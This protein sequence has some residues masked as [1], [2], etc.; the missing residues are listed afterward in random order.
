MTEQ[1]Q[2]FRG[3]ADALHRSHRRGGDPGGADRAS[4]FDIRRIIGGLFLL[5]GAILAIVGIVGS[6]EVRNKA[7]GV[8]VNLWTGLAM[9]V[10]GGLMIFWAL[11]R[12]WSAYG[13]R[14]RHR[15]DRPRPA[16]S[17]ALRLGCCAAWR[18]VC[19]LLHLMDAF[20]RTPLLRDW[21]AQHRYGN[22]TTRG[23]QRARRAR[24]ASQPES[25]SSDL[26]LLKPG[27]DRNGAGH[28]HDAAPAAGEGV[29]PAQAPLTAVRAAV[30]IRAYTAQR[31]GTTAC[32]P[33]Q[34]EGP[35]VASTSAFLNSGRSTPAKSRGA[36]AGKSA[37]TAKRSSSRPAP[38]RPSDRRPPPSPARA[39][40][41]AA[42][43]NRSARRAR[44]RALDIVQRQRRERRRQHRDRHHWFRGA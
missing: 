4:R 7:A 41:G 11:A 13:A 32:I 35:T 26:W 14:L 6:D 38:G 3:P 23:F 24:L 8:N 1:Q 9:L 39:A 34:K 22:A 18:G 31:S 19:R 28:R 20:G 10:F 2:P 17:P 33:T 44:A 5:Y 25:A 29:A 37:S 27:Q 30:P 43:A 12:R 16:G 40:A 36:G 21:F 42:S 15:P